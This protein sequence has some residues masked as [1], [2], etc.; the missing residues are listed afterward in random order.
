MGTPKAVFNLP[1]S[2]MATLIGCGELGVSPMATLVG[3]GELGVN[4]LTG[5]PDRQVFVQVVPP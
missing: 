5:I 4:S 1:V 2:Q 3:C